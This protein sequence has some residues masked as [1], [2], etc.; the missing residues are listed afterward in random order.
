MMARLVF[1]RNEL[2]DRLGVFNLLAFVIAAWMAG[3]HFL[4]IEEAHLGGSGDYG[5]CAA[6]IGG[7]QRVVIAIAETSEKAKPK[8]GHTQFNS[9][10]VCTLCA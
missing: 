1:D 10:S 2:G 3:E 6:C 4:P 8:S 7:G 9:G 5:Q